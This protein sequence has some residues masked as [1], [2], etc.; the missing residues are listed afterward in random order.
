MVGAPGQN[1]AVT[2]PNSKLGAFKQTFRNAY[3]PAAADTL[4]AFIRKGVPYQTAAD[5]TTSHGL[6][7]PDPQAYASA[8]AFAKQHNGAV[9][10]DAERSVPTTLGERL[11][12]S[13]AAAAV[14]G[15]ASGG[16]AGLSDVLGRTIFGPGFDAN[17]A[18]LAATN[19]TSDVIG[20]VG[21]G[22]AGSILAPELAAKY[23]P[24]VMGLASQGAAKLGRFAPVTGDAAY[25]GLYGA[26]ENPDDPLKGGLLGAVA[27]AGAGIVGRKAAGGLANIISP[28]EGN[29]GPLYDA[30]VFPTPGQRFAKSG[31]GGRAL[32]VVEQAMQSVPGWGA[33]P[34]AARQASRDAFQVG[35]FNNSLKELA[36]FQ[37]I[38][39]INVA[40][41]LPGRMGPGTGAHAFTSDQFNT[42]YDAA[43]SGMQFVPDPQYLSDAQAL[44]QKV[45]NGVLS[46][47]QAQQVGDVVNNAVV[48]RL[49]AQGGALNGDAYKAA[50][51]DLNSAIQTWGK[52]PATAP[53]AD[54]LSNYQTIFDNAARRNSDPAAVN[55]LDSADRGYA[56]L[57][58]IQRASELGGAAK[59]AG[60]FTPTNYAGAVKQMG[61]GVRSSAYNTGDA[62]G[63]DYAAAGLN[64]SDKL[65]DSGTPT[66]L[67]VLGGLQGAEGVGLAANGALG[68]LLSPKVAGAFAPYLPGVRNVTNRLIAPNAQRLSFLPPDVAS[69]LDGAADQ[70]NNLRLNLGRGAIPGALAY[71][72]AG[73]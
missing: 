50:S 2:D 3:D 70:I 29:F 37:N 15:A 26:N 12:S 65:A 20:N 38:N 33:A 66:R 43:R 22:I 34:A 56:Q 53:M 24:G 45:N 23:F 44:A 57:V 6:T 27:G 19:P 71:Y 68:T 30:G 52:N 16:T 39:G 41:S 46:P 67:A 9:N 62:L 18:A 35:A 7:A 25:G 60:T 73:Q 31:L 14:A 63:Q 40:T 5:Y 28:P 54:A 10:V 64:L 49:K 72:G 42:A 32:N 51:S 48:G 21:G 55:L 69:T 11:A 36:P 58:R 61:G 4:A 17:R 8:V 47:Q 59:D 13:P 1:L